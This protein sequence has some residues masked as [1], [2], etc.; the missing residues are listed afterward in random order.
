LEAAFVAIAIEPVRES[1]HR[2]LIEVYIALGNSACA[3]THYYQYR[4]LLQRELGV[5]PSQR[6]TRLIQPLTSV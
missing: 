2:T 5:L 4:A 6:I 3:V 1:T